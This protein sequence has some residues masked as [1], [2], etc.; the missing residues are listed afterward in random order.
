MT[1]DAL[2][3]A[4][5]YYTAMGHKDLAAVERHLHP[6]IHLT[7]PMMDV[8][9]KDAVLEAAKKFVEQFDTLTIRAK[10]ASG[11][12]AMLAYDLHCSEPIGRFRAAALVTVEGERVKS[13][14]LFFDP[15]SL[16]EKRKG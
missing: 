2:A 3:V 8:R 1:K 5:G 14:E 10:C 15:R 6:D 11:N 7:G 12:H 16:L 9:G 4:E 13:V